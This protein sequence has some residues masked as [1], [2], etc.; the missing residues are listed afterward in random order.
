MARKQAVEGE[1]T[2]EAAET[3]ASVATLGRKDFLEQVRVASGG[4]KKEVK[5]IVDAT[6]TLIGEALARGEVLHVPPLGVVR[7]TRGLDAG[8]K[9][10]TVKLR[11]A[12]AGEKPGRAGKET[13]AEADEAD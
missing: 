1:A 13:L 9:S 10:L 5:A 8:A 11:R 12:K 4:K 3:G 6:L 7:V 2:A